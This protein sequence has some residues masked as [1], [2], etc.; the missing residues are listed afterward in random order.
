MDTVVTTS[1]SYSQS[2]IPHSGNVTY[3]VKVT[4]SRG[5]TKVGSVNIYVYEYSIPS[6]SNSIAY[7]CSSAGV[8][9]EN[10]TYVNLSTEATYSP[11]GGNNSL[12]MNAYYRLSTDTSWTNAVSQLEAGQ[13]YIIGGGFSAGSSYQIKLEGWDQFNSIQK[14]IDV[15]TGLYTIFFKKGGRAIGLGTQAKKDNLIEVN[16]SWDIDRNGVKVF[17]RLESVPTIVFSETEPTGTEGAIWL[18]PV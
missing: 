2:L 5:R 15:S 7:R 9:S 1:S 8:S 10:G 16:E 14:I 3:Y 13:T 4:D 6:F 12:T 17:E 18:K 11:C